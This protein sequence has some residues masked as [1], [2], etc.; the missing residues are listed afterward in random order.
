MIVMRCM[1]CIYSNNIPGK[2]QLGSPGKVDTVGTPGTKVMKFN[3]ALG[4]QEYCEHG[5]LSIIRYDNTI[6]RGFEYPT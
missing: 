5:T 6:M 1:D 2:L 4:Y 3:T